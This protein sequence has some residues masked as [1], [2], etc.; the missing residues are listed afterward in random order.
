MK[1]IT[2]KN[3]ILRKK[4]QDIEDVFDI[5]IK[6]LVDVMKKVM[7]KNK[8][9][10]IAA[11]QLGILKRIILINMKDGPLA[12]INPKIIRFSEEKECGEEGC[13]SVPG[14]YG[15]VERCINVRYKGILLS[16]K[17]KED[18]A[19]GLFARVL[20]HEIDHLDGILFIDKI[21]NDEENEK[22]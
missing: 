8:G 19:N 9:I 21:R 12:L 5:R 13:L 11:P 22:I 6:R 17:K 7:K 10:G 20:Q 18:D 16:G 3:P 14:R 1:I 2:E 15:Q 4:S